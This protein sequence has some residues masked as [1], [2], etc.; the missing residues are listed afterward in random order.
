MKTELLHYL[1]QAQ[2]FLSGQ[3]L[4][5]HFG[6]SRTAVWKAVKSLQEDGFVI[7][8]VRNRGYRLVSI[9][10]ILTQE[11]CLSRIRGK[12]AGKYLEAYEEIDTTNR[13]A[14]E[15]GEEGAPSGAVVVAESQT[16]GKGRRGRSWVT[17]KGE[18]LAFSIM[19]RPKLPPERVSMLTLAAAM[20]VN[21]AIEELTGLAAQIKWPNDIVLGNKKVCGILTEISTELEMVRYVVVGIGINV[22]SSVFP[23]E[24]SEKASSLFLE[25]G[26]KWN[27]SELLG[28]VLR[29][30][31]HYFEQ[32]EKDKSLCSLRPEYEACLVSKGREVFLE[33]NNTVRQAKCLGISDRGG[34]IVSCKDGST[35]EIIS[36][37][38]SVRGIYGY[39]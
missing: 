23:E 13:R 3:E 31:E 5:E 15:L 19:L 34:L 35:E 33:E 38:V 11:S 39:I 29:Q 21:S 27:R 37:E 17:P 22:N 9:P 36:G 25:T 10:D 26:C 2:D 1:E 14:R 18:T 20:A 24:I 12:W 32:L 7:E 30:F 4:C 16:A 6:V 28:L 8:A